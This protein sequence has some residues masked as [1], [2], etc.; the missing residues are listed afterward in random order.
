MAQEGIV[1]VLGG[2]FS[3]VLAVPGSWGLGLVAAGRVSSPG[4]VEELQAPPGRELDTSSCFWSR[5]RLAL[6]PWPWPTPRTRSEASLAG[7]P[8]EP[9]ELWAGDLS[10]SNLQEKPVGCSVS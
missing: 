4:E 5:P 10:A 7:V 1:W 6:S 2:P 9:L 3:A 8:P